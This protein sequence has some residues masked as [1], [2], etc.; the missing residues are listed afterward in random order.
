MLSE[1]KTQTCNI[2]SIVAALPLQT[3]LSGEQNSFLKLIIRPSYKMQ[4]NFPLPFSCQAC[5]KTLS[6]KHNQM[7]TIISKQQA[8][9]HAISADFPSWKFVINILI[10]WLA[11]WQVGQTNSC[12]PINKALERIIHNNVHNSKALKRAQPGLTQCS[13]LKP[14]KQCH[15]LLRE[16]E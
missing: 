3:F 15:W 2:T 12:A 16:V 1:E 5:E 4:W 13:S 10:W 9:S 11:H 7:S 6:W 14:V 8:A